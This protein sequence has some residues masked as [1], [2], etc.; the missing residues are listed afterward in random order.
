MKEE[1]FMVIGKD[2][3]IFYNE[4]GND[5]EIMTLEDATFLAWTFNEGFKSDSDNLLKIMELVMVSV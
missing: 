3:Q 2:N 1:R 4:F 5:E